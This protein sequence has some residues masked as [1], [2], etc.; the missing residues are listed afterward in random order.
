MATFADQL[1]KS[2]LTHNL[3]EYS[4][5]LTVKSLTTMSNAIYIGYAVEISL[6]G[7]QFQ[8]FYS[9]FL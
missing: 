8:I 5:L 7:F 9:P 1:T 3:S 6:L 4:I 2:F